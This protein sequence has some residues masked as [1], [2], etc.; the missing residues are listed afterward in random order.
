[1]L[2]SEIF[3][4]ENVKVGLES[5]DKEELFQEMVSLL[6]DIEKLDCRDQILEKLW[7]R[8]KKMTTGI[9][10][11]IAIPHTS[12]SGLSKTAGVLGISK[13]GIDYDSLDG[14]PVFLVLM[15]IGDE[16]NPVEHLSVLK[17]IAMLLTNQDFYNK[18]MQCKNSFEVTKTI[19][20]FEDYLKFSK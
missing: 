13:K 16:K 8:E 15:L 14:K 19:S 2:I 12:I 4:P 7:E 18:I 17:N 11:K 3:K 10:A 9:S 5:Q 6:V 20:D 1:M